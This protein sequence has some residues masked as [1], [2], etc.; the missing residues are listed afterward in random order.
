MLLN[1][2]TNDQVLSVSAWMRKPKKMRGTG[3]EL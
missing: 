2:Y 1:A 3:A